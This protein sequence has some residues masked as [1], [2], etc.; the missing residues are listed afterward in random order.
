MKR[1]TVAIA[2]ALFLS[3]F[4]IYSQVLAQNLRTELMEYFYPYG[5][6]LYVNSNGTV[7]TTYELLEDGKVLRKIAEMQN[8]GENMLMYGDV[9][10]LSIESITDETRLAV[11]SRQ[12][13]HRDILGITNSYDQT[14]LFVLP[15]DTSATL[16]VEGDQ[17]LCMAYF[18]DISFWRNG[19]KLYRKAVKI[20]KVTYL[21]DEDV[22]RIGEWSY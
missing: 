16:W 5:K 11:V 21:E 22:Q 18:T 20:L 7:L 8:N 1:C 12:S 15:S 10:E 6:Y 3:S 2:F 9:Y 19:E 17:E 4:C 13:M 14:Y